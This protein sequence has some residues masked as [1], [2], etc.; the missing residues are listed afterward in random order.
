MIKSFLGE[1]VDNE[2]QQ[3]D[4]QM[5][6]P[7]V[8]PFCNHAVRPDHIATYFHE[9]AMNEY[10]FVSIFHCPNC[11]N[12][13]LVLGLCFYN[14]ILHTAQV[15]SRSIFPCSEETTGF[16][17][18]ILN[19][20]P[21]FTEIYKQSEIAENQNLYELVGMGYRKALEILIKDFASHKN[22]NESDK[23][24]EMLLSQ[25]IEQFIDNPHIKSLSKASAWLGND[26]THYLRKHPDYNINDLKAFLSSTVAIINAELE[27]EKANKVLKIDTSQ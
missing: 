6:E 23:I 11:E 5:D 12:F 4:F 18:N 2:N 21:R 24:K 19:L 10:R 25:V 13:F 7:N 16:S 27:V 26:E 22:P 9:I 14:D 8:C 17:E 1:C 15:E 3:F 20:S